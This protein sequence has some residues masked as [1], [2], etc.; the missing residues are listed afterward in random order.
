MVAEVRDRF[1]T[2]QNY[3]KRYMAFHDSRSSVDDRRIISLSISLQKH[4]FPKLRYRSIPE[5]MNSFPSLSHQ[6]LLA[7]VRSVDGLDTGVRD[8]LA[9]GQALLWASPCGA[10]PEDDFDLLDLVLEM[11]ESV[12]IDLKIMARLSAC[13]VAKVKGRLRE[14]ISDA[15]KSE[16]APASCRGIPPAIVNEAVRTGV[17]CWLSNRVEELEAILAEFEEIRIIAR[18]ASPDAEINILRQGFILLMTAFDAAI[19]DLVRVAL[20][21]KFFS[22]ARAFGKQDKISVS[23]IAEVGSFDALRDRLIEEQLKKRYIK[24][25]LVL[26]NNHWGVVCVDPAGTEKFERLIELVLRRNLHVHNRGVADSRYVS[27]MNLDG[28]QLG[29][30][31]VIDEAYWEMANKLCKDCV[32]R[33]AAWASV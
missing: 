22:L 20:C 6:E 5:M 4:G 17:H 31:A 7:L 2:E 24:D 9:E 1:T 11:V 8:A 23:D 14:M 26:L 28:L 13:V 3:I 21:H 15:V 27:D 10:L 32:E 30:V 18:T 33:V 16:G 12:E 25:L 19:F 29:D